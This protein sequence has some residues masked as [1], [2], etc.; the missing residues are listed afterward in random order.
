MTELKG[1]KR[2]Q[3][4]SC[5]EGWHKAGI[6]VPLELTTR[7]ELYSRRCVSISRSVYNWLVANSQNSRDAGLWLTPGDLE[8]ECNRTKHL[9]QDLA[10]V[11]EVSQFV[12]QGACR[13]FKNAYYRWRSP[14]IKA[15]KPVFHRKNR[16]GTG[17]FLAASGIARVKYDRHKRIRLPYLGSLRLPREL[18]DG[19]P[20]AVTLRRQNGR[21]YASIDH[22]KPPVKA[23]ERETQ[24]EGGFCISVSS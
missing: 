20:Y 19:I 21:W 6:V 2:E 4:S 14:G 7:Q 22:W 17:S 11:S 8:K 23:P 5:P 13:H 16:N 18:P 3:K 1:K 24:S 10:F 9:N 15:R 12:A